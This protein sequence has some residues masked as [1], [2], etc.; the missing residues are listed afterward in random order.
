MESVFIAVALPFVA[1]GAIPPLSR[2]LGDRVGYVGMVVAAASFGLVASRLGTT[3]SG[4]DDHPDVADPVAQQ[5]GQRR[6]GP[7]GDERQG[8]RQEHGLH[9]TF[10]A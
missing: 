2:L 10:L 5:A 9:R 8:D 4:G 1:A 6:D 7:C 3:G